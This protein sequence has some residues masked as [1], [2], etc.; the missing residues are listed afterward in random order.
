MKQAAISARPFR[1]MEEK[2]FSDPFR[3]ARLNHFRRLLEENGT[4][5]FVHH[6]VIAYKFARE[7]KKDS[8]QAWSEGALEFVGSEKE[9]AIARA[10][11]EF[12][13]KC[14]MELPFQ[15]AKAFAYFIGPAT[16]MGYLEVAKAKK[17]LEDFQSSEACRKAGDACK[18]FLKQVQL[19]LFLS[20]ALRVALTEA[21]GVLMPVIWFFSEYRRFR[22]A[23]KEIE[24]RD[25]ETQQNGGS[26]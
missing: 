4:R 25:R 12:W 3:T 14:V 24:K 16:A 18:Q 7:M 11:T 6:P 15:F 23:I 20:A 21:A 22:R 17:I 8:E 10:K 5:A 19:R 26:T 1:R 13:A 2:Y 9:L